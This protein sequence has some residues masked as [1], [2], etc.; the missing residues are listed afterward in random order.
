V[1]QQSKLDVA[2]GDR[3]YKIVECIELSN[4][5][6]STHLIFPQFCIEIWSIDGSIHIMGEKSDVDEVSFPLQ[7]DKS[8]AIKGD[9]PSPSQLCLAK[10]KGI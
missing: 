4:I 6:R 5:D 1:S 10:R 9:L 7:V 8:E 3:L 2:G